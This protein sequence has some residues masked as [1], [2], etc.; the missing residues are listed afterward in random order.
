M[1]HHEFIRKDFPNVDKKDFPIEIE[2]VL[3]YA[4]PKNGYLN[5]DKNTKQALQKAK[6]GLSKAVSLPGAVSYIAVASLALVV[7]SR[8]SG[9][10]SGQVDNP[11]EGGINDPRKLRSCCSGGNCFGGSCRNG[12]CG[13]SGDVYRSKIPNWGTAIDSDRATVSDWVVVLDPIR[14]IGL[15][16]DCVVAM[17]SESESSD[18]AVAMDSDWVAARDSDW[19]VAMDSEVAVS[20]D[21][22]RENSA[23]VG[24]DSD[25]LAAMDSEVAAAMD[26]DRAAAAVSDWTAAID[27]VAVK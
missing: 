26:S 23:Q 6:R 13:S 25:Q 1:H 3:H 12:G 22:N 27:S 10:Y 14:G 15:C 18:L 17:G 4:S 5:T 11:W 21:S 16:S 24:I 19:V 9:T 20:T 7:V 2:K 8:D